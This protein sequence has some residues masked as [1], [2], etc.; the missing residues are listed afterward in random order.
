ML[1]H[2]LYMGNIWQRKL[3]VNCTG[4]SYCSYQNLSHLSATTK[5]CFLLYTFHNDDELI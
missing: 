4:K 1:E 3:L 2:I 5:F